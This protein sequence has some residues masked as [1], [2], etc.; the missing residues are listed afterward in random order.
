MLGCSE[1]IR[2]TSIS[3]LVDSRSCSVKSSLSFSCVRS[4]ILTAYSVCVAFSRHR[5]TIL[6]TPLY[7]NSIPVAGLQHHYIIYTA[8]FIS[9]S[10]KKIKPST[11]LNGKPTTELRCVTCHM[12]SQCYLPPDTSERVPP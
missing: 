6:L 4:I 3:F 11:A 10:L 8:T 12:G 1:P 9:T 5:L 2:S 7:T